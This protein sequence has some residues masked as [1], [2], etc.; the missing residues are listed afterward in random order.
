[1]FVGRRHAD[2]F[3]EVE[4]AAAGEIQLKGGELRV[5]GLHRP[6]RGQPQH[7]GRLRAHPRRD[8]LSSERRGGVRIGLYYDFH[9]SDLLISLTLRLQAIPR[10][11]EPTLVE[12]RRETGPHP[13][14]GPGAT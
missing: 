8:Q 1:M 7:E 5:N 14:Y 2:I 6:P 9:G 10:R 13:D 3:V 12:A 4:T 11:D